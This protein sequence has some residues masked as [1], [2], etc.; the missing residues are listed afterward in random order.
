MADFTWPE[1]LPDGA[2]FRPRER[3]CSPKGVHYIV[4]WSSRITGKAGLRR[5]Q[6][7][8]GSVLHNETT[9]R[10]RYVPWDGVQGWTRTHEAQSNA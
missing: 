5:L 8:L 9:G 6:G 3:W 4:E 2:C 1:P 10:L 7:P